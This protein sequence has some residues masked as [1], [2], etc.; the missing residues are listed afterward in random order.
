M[1]PDATMQLKE[2]E[3][4]IK[5]VSIENFTQRGHMSQRWEGQLTVVRR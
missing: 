2:T 4:K 5:G 1:N 3:R